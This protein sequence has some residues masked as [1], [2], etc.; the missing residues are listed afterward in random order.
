MYIKMK[1][2]DFLSFSRLWNMIGVRNNSNFRFFR[3]LL[4][5]S[6]VLTLRLA[7]IC[8]NVLIRLA[9]KLHCLLLHKSEHGM[10]FEVLHVGNFIDL[11]YENEYT[12]P[13]YEMPIFSNDLTNKFILFFISC[14]LVAILLILSIFTDPGYS[15]FIKK[16]KA[17]PF[18][19]IS[20][21]VTASICF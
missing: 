15:S 1:M 4:N 10:V 20:I 18:P 14:S 13:G 9:L 2:I 19:N 12:W 6:R 7:N 11:L 3:Y 16:R 8:M 21:L 17:T 5:E